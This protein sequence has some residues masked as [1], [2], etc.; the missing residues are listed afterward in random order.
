MKKANAKANTR[1]EVSRRVLP[2]VI[3][4]F[5]NMIT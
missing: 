1:R 5:S 4:I 2:N 3:K